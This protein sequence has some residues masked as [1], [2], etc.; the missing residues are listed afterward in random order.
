MTENKIELKSISELSGMKFFIPAYQRGYR[1]TEQQVKDLLDDIQEFIEK[2]SQ[3]FYCIQPLVVRKNLSQSDVEKYKSELDEIKGNEEPLQATEELLAKFT[4][5]E[6]I[7]GQQ[8]LTTIYILLA[9]LTGK[10]DLLELEYETRNDSKEFLKN[11]DENK[12]DENID[13][14]HIVNA[15]KQISDWFKG[16]EDDFKKTFEENLLKNVKFIWYESIEKDAIRIFTRLNIGKI[17][18]TNAEL[19]K[20]LFLN[21][22]NF[23]GGDYQKIRL[24]QPEIASQ[25]DSIEYTLQNDE[26]W[27]FLN[28]AGYDKPTRI[29]FIF[30][31]ICKK[32]ILKLKEKYEKEL[33]TDEYKTFRYFYCWFKQ[34]KD[35]SPEC[36][37]N[38]MDCWKEVKT[39]FQ[40]FQE[41]F[42]DLELYHYVGFLIEQNV[43]ITGLLDDWS[44]ANQSKDGFVSSLK[45]QIK[46]KLSNCKDLNKQYE[47]S[48]NPKTQ[49][50]PI[51]LLHN[52]QTVI[53]QNKSFKEDEK[54]KLP[55]FY[56]FPFHLFKKEKWDVEH[57]DS[58]TE[59]SLDDPKTQKEW[60]KYSSVAINNA[61]LRCKI[62]VFLKKEDTSDGQND[63]FEK[64]KAEILTQEN[65]EN[66]LSQE[67]KDKLWNF[68]L[69]DS[70]TNRSYGNTI[71]PAKRRIIISK[72]Q[73]KKIE[74]DDDL[75][76]KEL[77]GDDAES[78]IAFIP[79]C[80][81]NVFLKYYNSTT[82]N[83]REWDKNDAAA[84]L[85]NIKDTLEYFVN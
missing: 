5:W 40:T 20:A 31:I 48:G 50:R 26:F 53:N 73:G 19:I 4:K 14:C 72:D 80:T 66:K 58:N 68:C 62:K 2:K 25:W 24:Q 65:K 51:L 39:L 77:K 42:N 70:S 17:S 41:W 67:E 15:K 32:D 81:K 16:K 75:N 43:E 18:L 46:G 12:A 37:I 83:L 56:K 61:K 52:I 49:C 29:D 45:E 10:H 79:P 54:Y 6:V 55:V 84:Y 22:S 82:N 30:D 13:Y 8:R 44:K 28:K 59:N 85:N 69:L 78:V 1:W 9:F 60:L 33:G 35:K 21:K 57:I 23:S 27:L 76:V 47:V 36:G 63:D 34:Q 38:I 64:I 71:F 11:I 3:G 7:D 74:V